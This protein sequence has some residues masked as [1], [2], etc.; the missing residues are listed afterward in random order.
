MSVTAIE[1]NGTAFQPVSIEYHEMMAK[2]IS[3]GRAVSAGANYLGIA[4]DF[5]SLS[6]RFAALLEH[7]SQLKIAPEADLSRLLEN[8]QELYAELNA[9]VMVSKAKGL[10]NRSLTASSV[11]SL[12]TKNEELLDLIDSFQVS[13]N[14]S[15]KTDF[16]EALTELRAGKTVSLESLSF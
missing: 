16:E 7:A 11:R 3:I 4:K 15:T 6:R 13:L 2:T 12:M 1:L 9:L 14:A 5:W 8:F 10:L